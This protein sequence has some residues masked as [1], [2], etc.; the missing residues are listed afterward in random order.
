MHNSISIRAAFIIVIISILTAFL[1]GGLVL[2]IGL[3]NPEASQKIYTFIS[4]IIGQGFMLLPLLLFLKLKNEPI[5]K[6]IR[7]NPIDLNTI[8]F[9]TIFS[10][11]IIILSDELDRIIQIFVPAP[12]YIV[13]LN[14]LLKPESLGG[15]IL[16]FVAVA[17]LAPLGEELLF[18]GFLQQFLEKH[19][20]DVTR[21]VL[22]TAFLFSMIHMNPY[23][24]LQIYLLGVL[25]GFLSWKTNSVIPSLIL[26]GLNN[27][28]AMLISFSE[29]ND[30]SF[31]L[32][33]GH[34]APWIILIAITITVYS[35]KNITKNHY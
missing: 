18:R 2:G 22:I 14:D 16:L 24:F 25:L 3:S 34:V 33:H 28:M 12:D 20:K 35:F 4:F 21:A 5:I 8:L 10:I 11:G 26:H 27:T 9:T 6:T 23:W 17:I 29:S 13:D 15:F 31:Y 19:W 7:L 32:W 30:N 1:S